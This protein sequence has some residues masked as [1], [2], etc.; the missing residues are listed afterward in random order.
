MT[1]SSQAVLFGGN[2]GSI[3]DETWTFGM[4]QY[5]LTVNTVGSGSV[6]LDPPGGVYN[7]DADVELTATADSG[8]VFS[9]WSGD[10]TGSANPDTITMTGDMT[11]TATF[12]EISS[13]VFCE[14]FESGFSLGV[15]VGEHADWF[16]GADD[17]GSN[18]TA[19]IGVW[20]NSACGPNSALAAASMRGWTA[21]RAIR[22][23]QYTANCFRPLWST[24]SPVQIGGC[25]S[26][27]SSSSNPRRGSTISSSVRMFSTIV[28]PSRSNCSRSTLIRSAMSVPSL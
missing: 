25:T 9:A 8:W 18:V 5:T 2:T 27:G 21:S 15:D 1:G 17:Q 11:V 24:P 14:D 20:C 22:A 12:L 13:G 26:G 3:N 16:D 23:P 10:L 4:A 28:Y 6:A 19:G 7:P